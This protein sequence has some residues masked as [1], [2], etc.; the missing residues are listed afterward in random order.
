MLCVPCSTQ[1]SNNF[2]LITILSYGSS[3]V[4]CHRPEHNV[5]KRVALTNCS[6]TSPSP[7][8]ELG[9]RPE[10]HLG[11]SHVSCITTKAANERDYIHERQCR[12]TNSVSFLGSPSTGDVELITVCKTS[13]LLSHTLGCQLPEHLVRSYG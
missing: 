12:F 8:S 4:A 5:I 10:T 3:I 7:T 1:R 11:I 6:H 2:V 13:S 9:S